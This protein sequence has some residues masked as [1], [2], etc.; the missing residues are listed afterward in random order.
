MRLVGFLLLPAG[1]IIVLVALA[2]LN[3]ALPRTIFVLAG[4]G[5]EILGLIQ[6]I[7]SHMLPRGDRG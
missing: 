1:W 4:V 3:L 2:L 7:R 6:V 5:V